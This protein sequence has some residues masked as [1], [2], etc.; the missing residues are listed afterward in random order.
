MEN[1][2]ETVT[3][4][5]QGTPK[6]TS[7]KDSAVITIL[8]NYAVCINGTSKYTAKISTSL[9]KILTRNII[10]FMIFQKLHL[11]LCVCCETA[12]PSFTQNQLAHT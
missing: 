10:Y 3:Q 1:S 7:S 11:Q 4:N 12:G 8:V 5:K 9:W 2:T 6:S